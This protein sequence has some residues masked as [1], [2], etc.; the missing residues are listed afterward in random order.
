M[1]H[2]DL[3]LK[4]SS[5]LQAAGTSMGQ[6]DMIVKSSLRGLVGPDNGQKYARSGMPKW[7]A[8]D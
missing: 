8:G 1:Q 2:P 4:Q 3:R 7:G 6:V 5:N